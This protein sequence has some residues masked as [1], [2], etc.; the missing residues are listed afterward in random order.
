V[1]R[2]GH[3]P[4][5]VESTCDMGP[6]DLFDSLLLRGAYFNADF[7]GVIDAILARLNEGGVWVDDGVVEVGDGGTY[8]WTLRL[9]NKEHGDRNASMKNLV[10]VEERLRSAAARSHGSGLPTVAARDE[11]VMVKVGGRRT[12]KVKKQG[13]RMYFCSLASRFLAF[14]EWVF[15]SNSNLNLNFEFE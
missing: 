10:V 1:S 4:L 3:P 14:F 2:K 13:M 12:A 5:L 11:A 6:P 8:W 15:I 9:S 7:V